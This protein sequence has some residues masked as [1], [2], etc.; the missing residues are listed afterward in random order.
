[1]LAGSKEGV[2]SS[3]DMVIEDQSQDAVQGYPA[4][5]FGGV[6]GDLK[7][8]YQLILVKN[9]LYQISVFRSKS[10]TRAMESRKFL[11]SF[12]ITN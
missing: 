9:R 2:I 12:N 8:S 3:L 5:T 4:V 10:G 6:T 1:M 11:R 7:V